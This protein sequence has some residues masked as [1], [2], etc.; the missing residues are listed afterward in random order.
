MKKHNLMNRFFSSSKI[1]VYFC[2]LVLLFS[3]C[4]TLPKSQKICGIDLLDNQSSFYISIPNNVDKDLIKRVLKTK[5]PMIVEKNAEK[6][7]DRIDKVYL[8]INKEK[9]IT[10]VQI[11]I[12]GNV[13]KFIIS[14]AFSKKNGWEINSFKPNE[15]SNNYNIYSN[16]DFTLAFPSK[17]LVCFGRDMEQMITNYDFLISNLSNENILKLENTIDDFYYDYL[18]E[19]SNEIR[20][21]TNNPK[22]FLSDFLGTKIN[23]NLID[24]A[25]AFTQNP[26]NK[27]QYLIKFI[28]HFKNE[29][30]LKAGKALLKI[31]FG[32]NSTD[33]ID[34]NNNELI[35]SNICIDKEKIINF[36]TL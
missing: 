13:P 15:K 29:K 20:F 1:P 14:Q 7:V 17:Q 28:F 12:D 26:A 24:V 3:S 10:D 23:L 5:V 19:N 4:T 32:L 25:G 11:A 2:T 16:K 36:F 21:F 8:G 6:I 27:N 9:S 30:F 22:N 18:K 33:Y 35:I 34:A 31:A